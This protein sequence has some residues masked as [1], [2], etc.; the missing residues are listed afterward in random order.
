MR[1][2]EVA[3]L[4]Q[5]AEPARGWLAGRGSFHTPTLW[6]GPGLLASLSF[7]HSSCGTAV[8]P[9]NNYN[10]ATDPGWDLSPY[11]YGDEGALPQGIV[12]RDLAEGGVAYPPIVRP[13]DGEGIDARHIER[14]TGADSSPY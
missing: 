9:Y 2:N 6:Q 13:P 10:C 8:F 4:V 5:Q 12:Q 7:T 14:E 11:W 1:G 3:E